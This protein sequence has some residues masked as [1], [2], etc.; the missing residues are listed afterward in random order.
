MDGLARARIEDKRGGSGDE[1]ILG[2]APSRPSPRAGATISVRLLFA[3]LA[4]DF[5]INNY[6]I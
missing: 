6:V 1:T 2:A 4:S 5:G 3:W